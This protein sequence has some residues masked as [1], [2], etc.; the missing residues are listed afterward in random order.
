[1]ADSDWLMVFESFVDVASFWANDRVPRGPIT[2]CHVAP[3]VLSILVVSKIYWGPGDSNPGPPSM[4]RLH[5]FTLTMLPPFGTCYVHGDKFI[6]FYILAY[7]A[8]GR[9]GA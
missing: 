2:G 6:Y 9:A 4:Q 1:V 3:Q 8:G 5:R 7:C